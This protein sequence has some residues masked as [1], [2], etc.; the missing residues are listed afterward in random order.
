MIEDLTPEVLA[1]LLDEMDR[2]RRAAFESLLAR[3][4]S[5]AA[6][7][8]SVADSLAADA[9]AQTP[10]TALSFADRSKMTVSV[11]AQIEPGVSPHRRDFGRYF[12]PA[13]AA[14]LLALN[15][16]QWIV[17]SRTPSLTVDLVGGDHGE[18]GKR[19]GLDYVEP[20]PLKAP[21]VVATGL[22][23]GGAPAA[24][25]PPGTTTVSISQ[26][27]TLIRPYAWSAFDRVRHQ[28]VLDLHNLPNV[29]ADQLLELWIQPAGSK[30]FEAVGEIPP[31]FYGGSGSITYKLSS[32]EITPAQILITVERR[33]TRPTSPSATIVLHGP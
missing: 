24:P 18:R 4:P 30:R 26:T 28:G 8:K 22:H 21:G 19:G 3:D 2:P 7:V 29:A 1:Y 25:L 5:V 23:A 14:A 9:L 12:W 13:A 20:A 11:L 16:G 6:L 32:T 31:Q 33:A 10:A 17:H 15:V 27:I